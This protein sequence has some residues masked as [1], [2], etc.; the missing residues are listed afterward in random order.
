MLWR[1]IHVLMPE[2]WNSAIICPIH[3]TFNKMECKNYRGI[4]RVNVTYKIFTRLVAKHLEPYVQE[5]FGDYQCGF[6]TGRSTTDQI[7]SLR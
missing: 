3:K 4:S 2:E 1:K 7:F 6:R 5:I